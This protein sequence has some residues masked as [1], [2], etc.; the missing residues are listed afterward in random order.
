M[1]MTISKTTFFA[2]A[3]LLL[4]GT[5]AHADCLDGGL[6]L[7]PGAITSV[8]PHPSEPDTLFVTQSYVA[9]HGLALLKSCDSGETWSPTALTSDFYEVISLGVDPT[10]TEMVYAQTNR[11][12]LRSEDG[13]ITWVEFD[14]PYG[15]IVFAT[16]G[17]LYLASAPFVFRRGA[18]ELEFMEMTPVPLVFDVLRVDPN[19]ASRLHVGSHYSVDSGSSWQRVLPGPVLDL[20]FSPSDPSRVAA[21][22]DPMRLS[23]DGGVNWQRP[24]YEEFSWF[25]PGDFEGHQVLFDPA[26]SDTIWVSIK[27]CGLFRSEDFGTRWYFADQGLTGSEF[28]CRFNGGHP[29]VD[30][31][32]AN[33]IDSD[34]YYAVTSDGLFISNDDGQSWAK[35]NGVAGAGASAPPPNPY[36]GDA[37]LQ[38]EMF[39]LPKKFTPP[40]T[41]KFTGRI[42]NYGP[43]TARDV[44]FSIPADVVSSSRGVCNDLG[45]EFGDLPSGATVELSFERVLLGGGNG[46][47]CNG[48]KFQISGR[49][50]AETSDPNPAN[51]ADSGEVTRKNDPSIIS[52]CAGEGLLRPVGEKTEEGGGSFGLLFLAALLAARRFSRIAG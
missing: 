27:G 19:D 35:A 36:S 7:E 12:A 44:R 5:A 18:G 13:G 33:P 32:Y 6:V 47:R 21:T 22:D 11:G 30:Q 8:L 23:I 49:V 37:D 40:A 15:D 28:F 43:D 24:N 31:L 26:D 41:L 46:T 52:G 39:K 3:A 50:D 14:M 42:T 16:D 45:C 17:T 25:I 20:Q 10:N 4:G 2:T 34:R 51:N 1:D 48:D 38:F 29:F 9:E